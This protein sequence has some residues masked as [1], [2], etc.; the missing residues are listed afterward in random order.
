MHLA[1]VVIEVTT[2]LLTMLILLL[3][4]FCKYLLLFGFLYIQI[5]AQNSLEIYK[6]ID[7]NH[8]N[9]HHPNS[10]KPSRQV[11]KVTPF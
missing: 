2:D 8:R 6:I 3:S 10:A 4:I 9:L 7:A 1:L 5:Y 11:E